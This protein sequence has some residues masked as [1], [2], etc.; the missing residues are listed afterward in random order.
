[1]LVVVIYVITTSPILFITFIAMAIYTA[2]KQNGK[3]K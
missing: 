1:M 2:I 3:L